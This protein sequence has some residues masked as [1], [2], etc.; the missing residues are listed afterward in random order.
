M[1]HA[2]HAEL[3]G[4]P[5]DGEL[6]HVPSGWDGD[7]EPEIKI[8][9]LSSGPVWR[10]PTGGSEEPVPVREGVYRRYAVAA[11]QAGTVW[12]YTWKERP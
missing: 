5:R 12:V 7:P 6:L 9:M 11:R 3:W 1:P 2:H 4:G 10:I 8:S